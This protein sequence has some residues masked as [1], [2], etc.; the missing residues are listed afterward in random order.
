MKRGCLFLSTGLIVLIAAGLF[1]ARDE[2]GKPVPSGVAT[3]APSGEDWI[4]LLDDVHRSAWRNI[5]D[6]KEIFEFEH[7]TIHVLGV[8]LSPLRYVGYAEERF[9]DFDLHLEFRLAPDANSGVFVR[10]QEGD[11]VYRGFEIQVIDDYG[12][13]PNKNGTGAI[14]DV[15]SPMFNLARPSGEWNSYDISLEGTQVTVVVNGWKVID[16]DFAQMTKPLGKFKVAY[17]E[18]PL[19][20]LIALQD[21]G[22][23]AWY[24]NIRVR[25]K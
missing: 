24:R 1:F 18:L 14:Y 2:A 23:E 10:V 5:T 12:D 25:R 17:A 21:H 6:D 15:V 22:G 16:T 3:E 9:G 4:D 19:D 20:G 8:T 13:P 7:D 11:P